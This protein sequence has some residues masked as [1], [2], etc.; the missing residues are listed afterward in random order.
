MLDLE[1]TELLEYHQLKSIGGLS[2]L[3]YLGLRGTGVTKLPKQIM[4]LEH[5]NTLDLRR[6][7]VTQLPAF[8]TVK[9]ASLLVDRLQLH[10]GMGEMRYLEELS[11]IFVS[12]IRP[13]ESLSKIHVH[14][15]DSLDNLVQL[16]N[17]SKQLRI[18]AVRFDGLLGDTKTY[19]QVGVRHFL[20]EVAKSS[21]QSLILHNYPH[22]SVDLLVDCWV[23][24]SLKKFELKIDGQISNIPQKMASLENLTHLHINVYKADA[25]GL[26]GLGK[27]PNLV[28]LNLTSEFGTQERCIITR[29]YFLCLKIFSYLRA[30]WGTA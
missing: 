24:T 10:R 18:L 9:L 27:L 15:T 28:F 22:N 3:R 14:D 16:I 5:L 20:E 25:E 29:D 21:I 26:Y 23:C 30:V 11:M 4:A 19:R 6:T 13:I 12:P 7:M 2:L 17:K 1:D 8:Q